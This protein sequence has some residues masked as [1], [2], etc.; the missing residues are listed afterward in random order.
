VQRRRRWANQSSGE[1]RG[2]PESRFSFLM[3][4]GIRPQMSALQ[5]LAAKAACVVGLPIGFVMARGA[6]RHPI[7]NKVGAQTGAEECKRN[8][9]RSS[10]AGIKF[11]LS[12][13]RSDDHSVRFVASRLLRRF[14]LCDV[15]PLRI[16]LAD[17]SRVRFRYAAVA[18]NL[19]VNP[20]AYDG[21]DIAFLRDF[22]RPGDTFVD[23]GANIG[24]FSMYAARSVGPGGRVVAIEPHPRTWRQLN[25][26]L[27][28][29]GYSWA[30]AICG[31]A[32]D[33]SAMLHLSDICSDDQ[34]ALLVG[35]P[36]PVMTARL[37]DLVP[38]GPVRLL[39]IDVEGHE[40]AVLAGAIDV[41]GRADAVLVEAWVA[42][43]AEVDA[44]L[45]D[46]EVTELA[47][48]A[49]L[50]NLLAVRPEPL[51]VARHRSKADRPDP[52]SLSPDPRA[53]YW[54]CPRPSSCCCP[55]PP[56]R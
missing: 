48:N 15:L 32:S 36:I 40:A 7:E 45:A 11:V 31:A 33:K 41:L 12:R 10:L 56:S 3:G 46:F 43:R 4:R 8:P 17:G 50:A 18:A 38:V 9:V 21:K 28:A 27:R 24:V 39:K 42:T 23:V 20:A 26:N 55:C 47:A 49:A 52:S 30:E 51:T 53:H 14:R 2:E 6:G 5:G 16:R 25:E 37:D 13:V 54:G 1:Y 35:G 22:L 19:W 34:N 29:N 44:A